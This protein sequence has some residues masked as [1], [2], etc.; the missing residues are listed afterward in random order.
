V[1]CYMDDIFIY[2][3]ARANDAIPRGRPM[4]HEDKSDAATQAEKTCIG[5]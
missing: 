1:S 3:R 2:T 4:K 5:Q